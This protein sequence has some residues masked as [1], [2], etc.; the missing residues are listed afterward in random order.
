MDLSSNTLS[1]S[2]RSNDW[3]IIPKNYITDMKTIAIDYKRPLW[4]V[5]EKVNAFRLMKSSKLV[6][7]KVITCVEWNGDN[8][9]TSNELNVTQRQCRDFNKSR[10]VIV[11]VRARKWGRHWIALILACCIQSH[12]Y[13][14]GVRLDHKRF[15]NQLFILSHRWQTITW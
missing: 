11:S 10:F 14:V 5:E 6:L 15:E 12:R 9:S 7:C 2:F 3:L 8:F 13:G 1:N 4:S